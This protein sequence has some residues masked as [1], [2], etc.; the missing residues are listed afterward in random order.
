M[1]GFQILRDWKHPM[2]ILFT[3]FFLLSS[4]CSST[5]QLDQKQTLL[6]MKEHSECE[7]YKSFSFTEPEIEWNK[8]HGNVGD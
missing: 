6:S 1:E 5:T 8:S 7:M 3:L 2:V 4:S